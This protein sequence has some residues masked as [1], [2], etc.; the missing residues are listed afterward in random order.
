[1]FMLLSDS[2]IKP[3]REAGGVNSGK[4]R[5]ASKIIKVDYEEF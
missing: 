5:S 1:M 4:W 3:E 2:L